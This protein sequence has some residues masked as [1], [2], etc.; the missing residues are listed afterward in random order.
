MSKN[1]KTKY[2]WYDE[3]DY[4]PNDKRNSR[5]KQRREK[6]LKNAIRGKNYDALIQDEDE[7]RR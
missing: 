2:R 4:D 5:E 6:K 1:G 7:W 3:E